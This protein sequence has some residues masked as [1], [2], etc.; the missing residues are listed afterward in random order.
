MWEP[1]HVGL[2]PKPMQS[3]IICSPAATDKFGQLSK[4]ETNNYDGS[5]MMADPSAHPQHMDVVKLHVY[6]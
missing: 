6:V 5:G 1:F 2:G 4:F 3:D